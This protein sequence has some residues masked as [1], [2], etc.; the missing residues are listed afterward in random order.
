MRKFLN[1]LRAYSTKV[2]VEDGCDLKLVELRDN[3]VAPQPTVASVPTEA[4]GPTGAANTGGFFNRP[5]AQEGKAKTDNT[6]PLF[7]VE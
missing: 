5:R 1:T 3:M 7:V 6:K 2:A 4:S